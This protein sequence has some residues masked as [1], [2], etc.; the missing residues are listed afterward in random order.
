MSHVGVKSIT[1]TLA[2]AGVLL[3][4]PLS[5]TLTHW[6]S[7]QTH[8]TTKQ[9]HHQ[10]PTIIVF[11]V[12]LVYIVCL[13]SCLQFFYI[14]YFIIFFFLKIIFM[15]SFSFVSN[16]FFFICSSYRVLSHEYIFISITLVDL[17]LNVRK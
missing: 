12:R 9:L 1:K 13:F 8:Q 4:C 14:F 17:F 11:I 16:F 7:R 3:L 10:P 2:P 5:H 6:V 15:A